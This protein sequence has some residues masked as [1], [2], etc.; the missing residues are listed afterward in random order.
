MKGQERA[1]KG[2]KWDRHNSGQAEQKAAINEGE[3]D[4]PLFSCKIAV[5]EEHF[6]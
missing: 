4:F 5:I 3:L 6:C 2:L 1:E